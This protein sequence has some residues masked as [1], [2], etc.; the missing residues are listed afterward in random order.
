MSGGPTRTR[1]RSTSPGADRGRPPAT[2]PSEQPAGPEL[3]ADGKNA[4]AVALGKLGGAKGGQARA[5]KL[6]AK[7]A[8][9]I[10]AQKAAAAQ[11]G[12]VKQN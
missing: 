10:N 8:S 1:P 2:V 6:S 5:A 3:T 12:K 9:E 4:A 7:E 11:W